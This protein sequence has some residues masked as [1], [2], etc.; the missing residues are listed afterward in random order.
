MPYGDGLNL[1]WNKF[2]LG[3]DEFNLLNECSHNLVS[4][5][6][7]GHRDKHLTEVGDR[8]PM[9]FNFAT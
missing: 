8:E 3:R 2:I 9:I 4:A 7:K 5:Q 1:K 6:R